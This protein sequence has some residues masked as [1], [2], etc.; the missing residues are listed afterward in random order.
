[1]RETNVLVAI[2]SKNDAQH[3][4]NRMIQTVLH[5]EAGTTWIKATQSFLSATMLYV[6]EIHKENVSFQEVQRFI[7]DSR[8]GKSFL[9]NVINHLDSN[10]PA[11]HSFQIMI[12]CK[13]TTRS[14]VLALSELCVKELVR[15]QEEQVLVVA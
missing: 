3:I 10:H 7:T 2:E 1:M 4:A 15:N 13:E 8:K 12:V 9:K 6:K 11:Y 5:K 14:L